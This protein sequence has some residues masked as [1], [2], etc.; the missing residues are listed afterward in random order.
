MSSC[1]G[2]TGSMRKGAGEVMVIPS[3]PTLA[4]EIIG[5]KPKS[6]GVQ[7]PA[8][9]H[10]CMETPAPLLIY[11][12]DGLVGSMATGPPSPLRISGQTAVGPLVFLTP[13]VPLAPSPS[14]M[15]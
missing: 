1:V 8:C 4:L 7:A 12:F 13:A 15:V 11:Q 6:V 2:S 5:F 14:I 10:R 3:P 9:E